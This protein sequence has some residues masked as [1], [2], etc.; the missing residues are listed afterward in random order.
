MT[1]EQL[2]E[3]KNFAGDSDEPQES[4]QE[5]T[6]EGD[7]GTLPLEMR[8]L[9]LSL[10]K[11][12][13]LSSK[14]S[15]KQW[16]L[17]LRYKE[18]VLSQLAN[19]YLTLLID[20]VDG[21]AFIKQIDTGEVEVPTLLTS[22]T[23]KLLDSVLLVELR[24]RL[25][26]AENS[27]QRATISMDEMVSHLTLFDSV[28]KDDQVKFLKRVAAVVERFTKRHILIQLPSKEDYEI[29]PI[30]RVLFTA[31]DVAALAKSYEELIEQAA[32]EKTHE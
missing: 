30:L 11:G 4:L 17:L 15:P 16:D 1:K 28:S 12:P 22:F 5:R 6:F 2:N 27:G 9:I 21:I 19:L 18:A 3:F 25:M 13:Y 8:N 14:E 20:E 29:S 26:N 23:Y 32:L 7:P 10:L 31:S 24:E